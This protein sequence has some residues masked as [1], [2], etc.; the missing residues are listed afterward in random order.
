M[1]SLPPNPSDQTLLARYAREADEQAFKILVEKYTPLVFGVALRRTGQ[2]PLAEEV[3]QNVF[4]AL[5]QKAASLGSQRSIGAWL[6]RAATLESLRALRKDSNQKRHI[7]MIRDRQEPLMPT[8]DELWHDVRPLLDELLDRLAARDRD[9]LI[10]HFFE[11]LQFPE[12]ARNTGVPAA[13]LQKRSVRALKKLGELLKRKGIVA[14]AALLAAGLASEFAVTAPAGLAAKIAASAVSSTATATSTISSFLTTM[15]TQKIVFSATAFLLAAAVPVGI[16]WA[17]LQFASTTAP[18]T[19]PFDP[20][21]FRKA[22]TT[23]PLDTRSLQRLV[24]TLDI[25]QVRTAIGVLDDLAD[26]RTYTITR[27]AFARWGELAPEDAIVQAI[28]P[29]RGNAAL[30]AVNGA[31][32]TWAFA[33]WQA[34]CEWAKSNK[35]DFLDEGY[36]YVFQDYLEVM[37]GIDG[38]TA[39]AHTFELQR[40]HPELRSRL[41]YAALKTW[42]KHEPGPAIAWMRD[43]LGNNEERD[44]LVCSAMQALAPFDLQSAMEGGSLIHDNEVARFFWDTVLQNLEQ[45]H[46]RD[47][48]PQTDSPLAKSIWNLADYFEQMDAGDTWQDSNLELAGRVVSLHSPSRAVELTRGIDDPLKQSLFCSGILSNTPKDDPTLVIDAANAIALDS[49]P[50]GLGRFLI[51]WKEHDLQAATK[52]VTELPPGKKRDLAVQLIPVTAE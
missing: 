11:G 1:N 20:D 3:S 16:G 34:A 44:G 29:S 4:V 30:Y 50:N 40:D 18:E 25:A 19:S 35:I 48:R 38:A 2:Q 41:L 23:E 21:A 52:W 12:I 27:A 8:D 9:I 6:H 47:E 15:T 43:Q 42:A 49:A 51:D 36:F 46:R 17:P 37:A 24:F 31:W 28:D 14:P 13:T 5:A 33:D 10:K 45:R 32:I 26:E 22:L 39:L 7:A